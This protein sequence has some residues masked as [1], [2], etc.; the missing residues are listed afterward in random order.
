[1]RPI[2]KENASLSASVMANR[3]SSEPVPVAKGGGLAAGLAVVIQQRPDAGATDREAAPLAVDADAA[4]VRDRLV[5]LG[6]SQRLL[7]TGPLGG[8][9][10]AA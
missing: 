8:L 1:M 2:D 3:L 10:R 9:C 5:L 7:P 6:G 4:V